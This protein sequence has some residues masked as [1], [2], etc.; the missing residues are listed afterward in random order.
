MKLIPIIAALVIIW[1]VPVWYITQ[2]MDTWLKAFVLL[3]FS[4]CTAIA[5]LVYYALEVGDAD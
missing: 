5:T 2:G 3:V 1:G 4:I